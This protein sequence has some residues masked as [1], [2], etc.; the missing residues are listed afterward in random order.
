MFSFQESYDLFG[1]DNKNKHIN[2]EMWQPT[3]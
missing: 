2:Y 3:I 1:A